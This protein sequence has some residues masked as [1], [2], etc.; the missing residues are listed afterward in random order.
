MGSLD[1]SIRRAGRS[2]K[3]TLWAAISWV[4]ARKFRNMGLNAVYIILLPKREGAQNVKDF[5]PISLVH[6]F[7]K[8]VTKLLANRLAGKL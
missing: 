3:T 2:S 8:L 1:A 5:R 4:W 6:T 7:A